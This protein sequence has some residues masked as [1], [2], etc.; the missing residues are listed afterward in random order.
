M[1]FIFIVCDLKN[2]IGKA[3]MEL[4]WITGCSFICAVIAI[5]VMVTSH[6]SFCLNSTN[7]CWIVT[8]LCY[9]IITVFLYFSILSAKILFITRKCYI[10]Q[11]L[12]SEN[13]ENYLLNN[14]DD[15]FF[16]N[17]EL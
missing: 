6:L 13:E 1:K 5:Y 9:C 2:R 10:E 3:G 17:M 4:L 16:N 12:F 15:Y 7:D 8:L 14:N 11:K